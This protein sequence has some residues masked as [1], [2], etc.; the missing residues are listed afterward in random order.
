MAKWSLFNW[1]K[2]VASSGEPE[3]YQVVKNTVNQNTTNIRDLNNQVHTA[4]GTADRNEQ[5]INNINTQLTNTVST[6]TVQT[7]TG[8]KTF[9]ANVVI[10]NN[11]TPLILKSTNNNKTYMLIKSSDNNTNLSIGSNATSSAIEVNRGDLLIQTQQANKSIS[12][13]TGRVKFNRSAVEFGTDIN[14]GYGGGVVK[15]IPEDNSTK[16]LQFFNNNANDTRRFNLKI[17]E[18]TEAT[19]PATKQYVD[20]KETAL[21]NQITAINNRIVENNTILKRT[22]TFTPSSSTP[23]T[24]GNGEIYRYGLRIT[25]LTN[26][27]VIGISTNYQN[28]SN[29]NVKSQFWEVSYSLWNE[30]VNIQLTGDKKWYTYLQSSQVPINMNIDFTKFEITVFYMENAGREAEQRYQ[31]RIVPLNEIFGGNN[32]N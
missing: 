13:N 2:P 8:A 17:N 5:S 9:N 29:S 20:N 3:D 19:N 1:K 22:Y 27:S 28:Q 26:V 10:S 7:I 4:Q 31:G 11:P 24:P 25:D 6:N 14:A 23:L 18:P 21:N 30:G 15:F 16:T 32:E 12:I